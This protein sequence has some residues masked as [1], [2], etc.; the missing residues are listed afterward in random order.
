VG[1]WNDDL[2]SEQS[3]WLH[4]CSK[5]MFLDLQYDNAPQNSCAGKKGS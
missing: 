5:Y 2:L 1:L 3:L 4:V